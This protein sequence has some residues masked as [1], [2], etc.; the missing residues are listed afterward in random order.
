MH[1]HMQVIPYSS[2]DKTFDGISTFIPAEQAALALNSDMNMFTLPQFSK[3][4]HV[5][6]KIESSVFES[7]SE[8]EAIQASKTVETYYWNCLRFLGNGDHSLDTHYNLLLTRNFLIVVLR[9]AESFSEEGLTITINSLGFAGTHAVKR[10]KDLGLIKKYGPIG[11][12]E[13]VSVPV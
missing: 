2:L 3:F 10:E 4:K 8:D 11:I 1:K 6:H 5:F 9:Q 13:K 12:L 7:E